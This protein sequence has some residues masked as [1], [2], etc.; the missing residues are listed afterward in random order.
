MVFIVFK[1]LWK[2][3]TMWKLEVKSFGWYL[4]IDTNI[5]RRERKTIIYCLIPQNVS[6]I[7]WY[8]FAQIKVC[9]GLLKMSGITSKTLSE[10]ANISL[11]SRDMRKFKLQHSLINVKFYTFA[12][13]IN[14]YGRTIS[15]LWTF[16]EQKEWK[17]SLFKCKQNISSMRK[18]NPLWMYKEILEA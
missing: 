8:Y 4:L 2:M 7:D 13:I 5:K 16:W 1:D 9:S 15:Q 11:R 10:S 6:V 3:Q 17:D 14:D 18:T 12:S